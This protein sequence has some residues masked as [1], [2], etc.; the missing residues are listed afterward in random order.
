MSKQ[1]SLV[2]LAA[3]GVSLSATLAGCSQ[4]L[5]IEEAHVDPTLGGTTAGSAGKSQAG[6]GL[7][8]NGAPLVDAGALCDEYCS[9]VST[10]CT[11]T[12]AQYIDYAACLASCVDFPAGSPGDTEG[13]TINCRL[14][15]AQKAATEPYTYCTWAGPGGDGKCGSNCDG[16]CTIMMQECTASSTGNSADYFPTLD[17]C[18]S[19]CAA[20]PDI[21]NYAATNST[22]QV[23]SDQVECRLYHADAA[24]ATNDPMTH[25]PHAMGLSLCVDSTES[26]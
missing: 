15:Y 6:I 13:N 11:D 22:Q 18:E 20:L 3:I 4:V 9:T 17:D 14:G 26:Y 25:C 16:F 21:G 8:D 10:G 5:D 12:H 1:R 2:N 24:A 19:T 7:D 23:G